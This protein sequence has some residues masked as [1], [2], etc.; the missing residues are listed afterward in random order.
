MIHAITVTWLGKISP[1]GNNN[2]QSQIKI[3]STLLSS[4][5]FRPFRYF[6]SIFVF[7]PKQFW[8]HCRQLYSGLL[9]GSLGCRVLCCGLHRKWLERNQSK[10][11]QTILDRSQ[12][13]FFHYIYN[14]M[15]LTMYMNYIFLNYSP[16]TPLATFLEI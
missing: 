15:K 5:L 2:F 3:V 11:F 6:C 8:S 9:N 1:F 7:F 16:H 10:Y 14:V 4:S 12:Y 13:L